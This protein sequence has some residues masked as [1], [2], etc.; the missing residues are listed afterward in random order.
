MQTRRGEWPDRGSIFHGH[1]RTSIQARVWKP[2]LANQ[3][4]LPLSNRSVRVTISEMKKK[5]LNR[6]CQLFH[7]I[8]HLTSFFEWSAVLAL[9][10]SS[11]L[12]C[13]KCSSQVFFCSLLSC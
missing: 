2:A 10:N 1:G 13:G 7:P 9:G 11:L 8:S 4:I 6:L 5:K 12:V 3:F